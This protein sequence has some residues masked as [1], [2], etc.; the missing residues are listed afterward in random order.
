MFF[1]ERVPPYLLALVKV[2]MVSQLPAS[3]GDTFERKLDLWNKE[4]FNVKEWTA[5]LLNKIEVMRKHAYYRQ[6]AIS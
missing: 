4:L 3:F 6:N 1:S 2:L 5:L